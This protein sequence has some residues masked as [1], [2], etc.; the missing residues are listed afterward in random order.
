MEEEED[1]HTVIR[2]CRTNEEAHNVALQYLTCH[3]KDLESV[4]FCEE[5]LEDLMDGKCCD[6][7]VE[8]IDHIIA[9]YETFCRRR[10]LKQIL[11][12]CARNYMPC[13]FRAV[14]NRFDPSERPCFG[15]DVFDC[16]LSHDDI[17]CVMKCGCDGEEPP[18]SAFYCLHDN[19]LM[20]GEGDRIEE[21]Q[22][23]IKAAT[24]SLIRM[25]YHRHHVKDYSVYGP[26]QVEAKCRRDI[27]IDKLKEFIL[28]LMDEGINVHSMCP[29]QD[30]AGYNDGEF[31]EPFMNKYIEI[32][33]E[34]GHSESDISRVVRRIILIIFENGYPT[35]GLLR[36][37]KKHLQI[38]LLPQKF[39]NALV[40]MGDCSV[41]E[42][43]CCCGARF[44]NAFKDA[45]LAATRMKIMGTKTDSEIITFL[46]AVFSRD[47]G[48][49]SEDL[50]ASDEIDEFTAAIIHE[51]SMKKALPKTQ[52]ATW[53]ACMHCI[54]DRV[55]MLLSLGYPM[56]KECY[57]FLLQQYG[58]DSA[59][60][61]KESTDR[62]QR[63][64][65]FFYSGAHMTPYHGRPT[66]RE[67][68]RVI[69]I[70]HGN[71]CPVPEYIWA[72]AAT[73]GIDEIF[74]HIQTLFPDYAD[75]PIPLCSFMYGEFPDTD[76]GKG[77]VSFYECIQDPSIILKWDLQCMRYFVRTVVICKRTAP[78]DLNAHLMLRTLLSSMLNGH[79]SN[80]PLV[81]AVTSEITPQ[82]IV[83]ELDDGSDDGAVSWVSKIRESFATY[84]EEC[85]WASS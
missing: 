34:K 11:F 39:V 75:R 60:L 47:C 41:L 40:C 20:F 63:M 68:I 70:L 56:S 45:A 8:L 15:S 3:T 42:D 52:R 61:S 6:D 16:F 33:R 28:W 10:I 49:V 17:D 73:T 30:V 59:T 5:F 53:T 43:A 58:R 65:A 79:E 2:C 12:C 78:P 55:G 18:E 57:S 22:N 29:F 81:R 54:P 14:W 46:R 1:L 4:I 77:I 24:H 9:N 50:V 27:C 83:G 67:F 26:N 23:P 38:N 31:L 84:D 82:D 76:E 25:E 36:F 44:E 72:I 32:H 64:K 13:R 35:V 37:A 48:C 7:S 62:T 74:Q 51:E 66:M 19:A 80:R 69:N 71:A 85:P 21:C